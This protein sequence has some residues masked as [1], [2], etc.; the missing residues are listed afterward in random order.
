MKITISTAFYQTHVGG[1]LFVYDIA[2]ALLNRG[3]TVRIHAG[4]VGEL[5]N[6]TD[7]K[8]TVSTKKTVPYTPDIVV[9][10]HPIFSQELVDNTDAPVISICHSQHFS[11]DTP[12]LGPKVKKHLV[13]D[14]SLLHWIEREHGITDAEVFKNGVDLTRFKPSDLPKEYGLIPGAVNFSR[15]AMIEEVI[16]EYGDENLMFIGFNVNIIPR[17]PNFIFRGSIWEVEEV[18]AKAKWVAGLFNGRV[19]YE[20]WACGLEYKAYDLDGS[21]VK[22]Q[23]PDNFEEIFS[24]DSTIDRLEGI[25]RSII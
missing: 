6:R 5:Y 7:P 1:E 12:I 13:I 4:S 3:H 20:A 22:V 9:A 25:I 21:K 24:L 11:V 15:M 2:H 8:I 14:E 16:K 23:K 17:R 19:Q 18:F 10:M